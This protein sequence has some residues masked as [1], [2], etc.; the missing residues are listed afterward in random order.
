M[1][2][3][4]MNG[5][6][7]DFMVVDARGHDWDFTKLS[8]ELCKLTGAD[9]FMALDHSDSG[10]FR[11]H[12]YNSDGSRGEMCGNGA[13]CICRFAYEK[14]IAGQRMVI[15][16]DA[17]P[18]SGQRIRQSRYRVGLNIPSVL[19]LHRKGTIAYTELGDPPSPS[20]TGDSVY[21]YLPSTTIRPELK[22]RSRSLPAS[23]CVRIS[24]PFF[25]VSVYPFRSHVQAPAEYAPGLPPLTIVASP[26]REICHP[27]R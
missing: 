9:G 22:I 5:A 24:N 13:R 7:N 27:A 12:F 18:V 4:H 26:A 14:G 23:S 20:N 17:G 8:T 3:W 2:I 25:K 19:D 6:G 1:D 15:Q 16:T 10:D 21:L 11:L